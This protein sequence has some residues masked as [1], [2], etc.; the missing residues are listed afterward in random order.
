[1]AQ[2]KNNKEEVLEEISNQIQNHRNLET[3]L[4]LRPDKN[5]AIGLSNVHYFNENMRCWITANE[6]VGG[7][8][9]IRNVVGGFVAAAPAAP[10]TVTTDGKVVY[11]N[12][13]LGELLIRHTKG[14]HEVNTPNGLQ[15]IKIFNFTSYIPDRNNAEATDILVHLGE[16]KP[17][18]FSRLGLMRNL[19]EQ[20]RLER[21]LIQENLELESLLHEE[22]N[23][24]NQEENLK[25]KAELEKEIQELDQQLKEQKEI[26]NS[27]WTNARSFIRKH[28]ELRYQP[29]LDPWQEEIKRCNIFNGAIAIN[30][31]PGTGK[32]TALIQRIKFLTDRRAMLGEEGNDSELEEGYFPTMNQMQQEVV[33]GSNNWLFF[34]P[35]ELLKLFLKNS[36]VQEGLKADDS[37]VWVWSEYKNVLLKKYKFI[38]PET[39]NPFL[40]LKKFEDES[41]FPKDGK[42][43]K[44]ILNDFEQ[45]YLSLFTSFFEQTIKL[46][47]KQYS[48]KSKGE[49]LQKYLVANKSPKNLS[50]LFRI[51]F[52]VQETYSKDFSEL[53]QKYQE[54]LKKICLE[55]L[56]KVKKSDNWDHVLT[57]MTDWKEATLKNQIE[58]DEDEEEVDGNESEEEES[59][60][61]I[62]FFILQQLR[63]YIIKKGLS[64][65]DKN[66]KLTVKQTAAGALIEELHQIEQHED[67]LVIAELSFFNK[68]FVKFTR[69]P[70][71][72]IINPLPA[73]Y[74]R[75]R[76][77][78]FNDNSKLWNLKI[79]EAVLKDE[80]DRNKRIHPQ[81]QAFLI[82]FANKLILESR[83][84]SKPKTELF[85]HSYVEAFKETACPVIG[86][87]EATDFHIID[88]LAMNS[89]GHPDI[90]S[91]TYSGDLMQRLTNN[92]IQKWDELKPLITKFEIKN[93]QI[94]Y[95]QSPT[96]LEI[97][98]QIY[99]EA[100]GT[101]AEYISFSEKDPLEPKALLFESTDEDE[102]IEWIA[103]RILEI[104]T[105]YSGMIPSIAIFLPTNT[106]LQLFSKKL[107]EID[108]LSDVGINVVAC[109]NG[110]ILGDKNSIRVF[111]IDYVKGL[112]FEAAFFHNIDALYAQASNSMSTREMILKNI[113]VGLSRAAFYL[114]LTCNST[115]DLD[116]IVDKF[117]SSSETWKIS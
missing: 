16:A 38:N 108:E 73:Y 48:W 75:Y 4:L 84:V 40:I 96:L 24:K 83:K 19:L 109:E 13:K 60:T 52:Y 12:S 80:K 35:S 86:I 71:S 98:N 33:F 17:R 116:F 55:I 62:D 87:D 23:R 18:A 106:N 27:K 74:K 15:T 104:Y 34:S 7:Y 29:I 112:E 5:L 79:L 50:E 3:D 36:M 53:I 65:F 103:S 20:K 72:N 21:Q 94:S 63:A 47:L 95:R 100:T 30:G 51:Y 45:F 26:S 32:T 115:S 11:R 91:V 41:L 113:Y 101:D 78:V 117:D 90:S 9:N 2:T 64:K 37:R 8:M 57:F 10:T 67:F 49:S 76:A 97:A 114:A 43:L 77:K 107:G 59:E 102:K 85:K 68:Y 88:L 99:S 93:L 58:Q 44:H 25:R 54:T 14:K 92:G 61:N 66:Q 89:L 81:E 105:A 1:M 46:D 28:A 82:Y 56:V 22:E 6:N 31:G 110:Q 39:K 70:V 42:S 69:G 111:S